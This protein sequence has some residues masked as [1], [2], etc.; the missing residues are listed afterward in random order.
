MNCQDIENKISG[1]LDGELTGQ[2]KKDFEEHLDS[3]ETCSLMV[4]ELREVDNML[5]EMEEPL[6]DE[7]YWAGFDARLKEKIDGDRSKKPWWNIYALIRRPMSWAAAAALIIMMLVVPVLKEVVFES[8]RATRPAVQKGMEPPADTVADKDMAME[9]GKPKPKYALRNERLEKFNEE[10]TGAAPLENSLPGEDKM[11]PR[12]DKSERAPE[13]ASP[14]EM[15]SGETPL[16]ERTT[17]DE[18]PAMSPVI[19]EKPSEPSSSMEMETAMTGKPEGMRD[20]ISPAAD[21]EKKEA[22]KAPA[23]R[24]AASAPAKPKAG[25]AR[26]EAEPPTGSAAAESPDKSGSGIADENMAM[27]SSKPAAMPPAVVA[28]APLPS[29]LIGDVEVVAVRTR[30]RGG[31][32]PGGK[33]V[34]NYLATSEVVLMKL[35]ALPQ[36]KDDLDNLRSELT[37][38]NYMENLNRN[39]R[40]FS[41]DPILRRHAQLMQGIANGIMTV[42]PGEVSK[43]QDKVINSGIIDE[44]R[45]L[46]EQ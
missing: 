11:D 28:E 20:P 33:E 37:M 14:V 8:P 19:A 35:V 5:L 12:M 15:M 3:C 40:K 32:A 16:S 23:R 17:D 2:E 6:P 45:E 31:S 24:M 18:A 42:N 7:A 34:R 4:K 46:K 26:E 36:G 10:D 1:Y 38:S 21:K 27:K 25:I 9:D 44:T 43:L 41:K 29:D 30:S 13:S 39:A 22:P